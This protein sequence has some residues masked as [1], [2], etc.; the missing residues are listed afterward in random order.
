[1][2]KSPLL[3]VGAAVGFAAA[4]LAHTAPAAADT[5][6]TYGSTLPAPH[7]V[8]EK[9]LAP[10]FE[11]IEQ[12]TNGALSWEI[13]PGGAMGG[14]KEAVQT[15]EDGVVDSGLVL[16][17]Y[18]RQEV[19]IT[20]MFADMIAIPDDFLVYAAAANEMQLLDCQA[21]I[22]ER[23]DRDLIAMAY[24][25]PDPYLLMCS[26][27]SRTYADLQNKKT[28]ASG[29]MGVLIDSFGAT[30]VTI[31]SSE[32]YESLQRGQAAC[33]V[34]SSAWLDS[35]GLSD[36]VTTVIDL[37]MGSYFNAGLLYMN[38]SV[39]DDLTEDEQTAIRDNLAGL[40]ADT[41]FAYRAEGQSAV[42]AAK[43]K[44]VEFVEPDS[45]M[46]EAL[47]EFRKGELQNTIETAEKAGIEGAQER[48]D[49]FMSLVEKWRQ[50]VAETGDDKQAFTEALNR[51]I[52]SKATF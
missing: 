21:C 10:F 42:D 22:D 46:V 19:P 14:V 33:S 29:R 16:D 45:E 9:G 41:L 2:A 49:A 31:P 18:T 12:Q 24:Y 15:I 28:R 13:L 50:I 17:I 23:T 34:A 27:G 20:S 5:N 43:A 36:V 3:A 51:E 40:V 26:D 11:R 4:A 32:V 52:F 30:T 47:V 48:V 38:K 7:V 8:H 37:P 6:L 25:A 1:M 35:Y 39:Y 44:G